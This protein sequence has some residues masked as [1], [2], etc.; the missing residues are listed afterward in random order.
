MPV[1]LSD[2]IILV[3]RMIDLKLMW[4]DF[5]VC[6]SRDRRMDDFC[7]VLYT[8]ARENKSINNQ[9]PCLFLKRNAPIITYQHLYFSST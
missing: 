1:W 7:I 3:P 9:Q 5:N 6:M 4:Y 8:Y 2:A